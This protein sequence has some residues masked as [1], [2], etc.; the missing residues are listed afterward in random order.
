MFEQRN[1][2]QNYTKIFRKTEEIFLVGIQEVIISIPNFHYI[3]HQIPHKGVGSRFL[4]A[5]VKTKPLLNDWTSEM[6]A[7]V[8]SRGPPKRGGQRWISQLNGKSSNGSLTNDRLRLRRKPRPHG[9][10]TLIGSPPTGTIL[11]HQEH[12]HNSV[13]NQYSLNKQCSASVWRPSPTSCLT[14]WAL[15]VS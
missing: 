10:S 5:C 3:F 11:R 8:S 9:G 12:I 2:T 1:Y 13:S 7:G 14:I 4:S 15:S 6:Y